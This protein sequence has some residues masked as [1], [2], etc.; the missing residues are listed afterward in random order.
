MIRNSDSSNSWTQ[1]PLSDVPGGY[2]FYCPAFD[3]A[4]DRIMF[5]Q[6][7][8][9]NDQLLMSA[10][11]GRM[12]RDGGIQ[13]EAERKW[14][15]NKKS[16]FGETPSNVYLNE[17]GKRGGLDFATGIINGPDVYIP[18]C[19]GGKTGT[20]FLGYTD[21][22]YNNGVFHSADSGM[23]WQLERISDSRALG[24]TICKTKNYYYYFSTK[25]G[26][27]N[28]GLV[29]WFSR[30]PVSGGKWNAPAT[31]AKPLAYSERDVALAEGDTVHL[32]WLDR[33]H[34]KKKLDI[35]AFPLYLY[36]ELGNYEIAYCQRKDSDATWREDVILSSGLL[37]AY[38]P[39][40]SVEGE[41][42]V[43]VWV[44]GESNQ[45]GALL[46]IYYATSKDGGETW[47]RPLKITDSA[48]DGIQTGEP[49]V[50]VQNGVIHLFY[51]QGKE[52]PRL[53][54]G[55]QGP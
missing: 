4:N 47:A 6:G 31:A 51:I 8:T 48:K 32:C 41:R 40:M 16:F 44:G 46:D 11:L 36:R 27:V 50:A 45:V 26:E 12:T 28:Q 39:R 9:E 43:V 49:Q 20:S 18:Y 38:S 52:N 29:L 34:E 54:V 25:F 23:T 17:P 13:V 35:G 53:H 19:L 14:T 55:N 2:P 1:L 7:Y 33:R 10:I 21:G 24:P 3:Q 30:K 5:E 42:I 15:T 22:P 37:F